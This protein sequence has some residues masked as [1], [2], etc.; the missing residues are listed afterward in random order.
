MKT[1][2]RRSPAN[3]I[4][5]KCTHNGLPSMK[6]HQVIF[7]VKNYIWSKK[8]TKGNMLTFD[9]DNHFLPPDNNF[10]I[11]PLNNLKMSEDWTQ[12]SGIARRLELCE[13]SSGRKWR[14]DSGKELTELWVR[15]GVNCKKGLSED[16][17]GKTRTREED[18]TVGVRYKFY[19][20]LT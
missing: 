18:G 15:T 6:D 9:I 19:D 10:S 8:I 17:P 2:K 20:F 12:K 3:L 4:L 16:D 5:N 13:D 7:Y 14:R 1:K 11:L